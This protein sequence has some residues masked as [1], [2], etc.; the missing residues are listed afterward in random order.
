MQRDFAFVQTRPGRV[1]VGWG[2]FEQLPFRRPERPAFYVSDFFL[3]DP[4]PWRH[5]AEWEELPLEE[6]AARFEDEGAPEVEWIAPDLDDFARLFR[7]AQDGMRR[8][9]FS[10]IVPVLFERGR[11]TVRRSPWHAFFSRLAVLPPGMWAYGFQY[12]NHGLAGATPEMLF[13]AEAHGYRTMALAGTRPVMRAQELLGDPKER[14]EHRLVVDDIVRRLSPFGNV[15][16]GPLG[17]MRLPAIA[18]LITPIFFAESGGSEKMSF[19]E[20]VRRLHPT[21]ALG[22]SPRTQAGERWLREADRGIKRRVF[23]AP[24]G[25]ER[26]DRSSLA[27]VAIRNV[28][29]TGDEVR[30]GSGA[31]L[32]AESQLER[33][34]EELRQKREQVKAL[35]GIAAASSDDFVWVTSNVRGV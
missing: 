32:L 4:H 13:Q 12:N 27:L 7:P 22:V 17:L 9:D 25:V 8:G 28:Q 2:P 30:V 24:F 1:F 3:D 33:E 15:E 16:I 29:W 21:A 34:F 19:A 11:F 5:P 18:H 6:L 20:M 35:F 23:G 26:E 31:G 14:R 10:K